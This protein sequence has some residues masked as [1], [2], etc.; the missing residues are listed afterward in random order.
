MIELGT[1]ETM[2]DVRKA[3]HE[4]VDRVFYK[5]VAPQ[6]IKHSP[7]PHLYLKLHYCLSD[8]DKPPEGY[9]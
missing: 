5:D 1:G 8:E 4:Y 2:E 9:E 6:I 7:I 3:I